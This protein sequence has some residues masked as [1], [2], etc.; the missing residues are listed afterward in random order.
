MRKSTIVL[1]GAR[2]ARRDSIASLFS[3][4]GVSER[5]ASAPASPGRIAGL[6]RRLSSRRSTT[7][8]SEHEE[9]PEVPIKSESSSISDSYPPQITRPPIARR[10]LS[11]QNDKNSTF[12]LPPLPEFDRDLSEVHEG[13][14]V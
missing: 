9:D 11:Q 5:D 1:R 6:L 2:P 3:S 13:H 7:A 10:P 8:Y 12:R 4:S 14:A